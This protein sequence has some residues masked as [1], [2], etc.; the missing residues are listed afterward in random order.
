MELIKI[1]GNTLL[2]RGKIFKIVQRKV[3]YPQGNQ[4]SYDILVHGGAVTILPLD[5]QNNIWF[6]SQYR[7]AADRMILE[8][9]A[10]TLEKN[11][12][13][14]ECAHRE[15]R[16]EIGMAA[17]KMIKI[18]EFYLAPGYST[19]YMYV[20]LARELSS[21]PLPQDED[22][23]IEIEKYSLNDAYKMIGSGKLLDAKSLAA[24]A[25]AKDHLF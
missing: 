3:E 24:M 15:L 18:G 13:L 14:M 20:F 10:G 22:E 23:Y 9:P 25:L 6:I 7:P 4:A 21:N 8:L 16:E 19:E 11:E 1:I 12:D 2:H 17:S 5:Q